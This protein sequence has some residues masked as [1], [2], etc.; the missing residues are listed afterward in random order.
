M[1]EG[2]LNFTRL[3]DDP[4]IV[5]HTQG[6]PLSALDEMRIVGSDGRDRPRGETGELLVRGP[7]ILG[8]YYR[9]PELN[10]AAFTDGWFR[11]G[12]VVRLHPSGNLV[13]E[14][15]INELIN[16]AGEKI[17]AAEIEDLLHRLPEVG[18]AAVVAVPDPEVG[19]RVC[20]CIVPAAGCTPAVAGLRAALTDAD[21]KRR[22]QTARTAVPDRRDPA[23]RRRQGG[24]GHDQE[25]GLACRRTACGREGGLNRPVSPCLHA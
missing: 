4:R 6:W 15:R 18:R 2:M 11:T 8:G 7:G 14:S 20:A 24:Q 12:D 16:R 21:G 3:H 19:E 25:D 9:S 23:H 1:S 22:L 13:V 17:S 10:A 5:H